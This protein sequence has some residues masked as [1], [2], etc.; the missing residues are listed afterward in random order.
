MRRNESWLRIDNSGRQTATGC[1]ISAFAF[2]RHRNP[3][4]MRRAFEREAALRRSGENP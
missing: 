2:L 1:V 4:Y 3:C